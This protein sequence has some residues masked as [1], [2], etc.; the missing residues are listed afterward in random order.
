[1]D[2][3]NISNQTQHT[4]EIGDGKNGEQAKLR[5]KYLMKWQAQTQ[6]QIINKIYHMNL[7]RMAQSNVNM[8]QRNAES[9]NGR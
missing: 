1:M 9:I 2:N 3:R 8:V 5:I 4:N 7:C 6:F